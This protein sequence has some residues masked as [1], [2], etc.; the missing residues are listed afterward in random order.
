VA[1]VE[2]KARKN[3]EEELWD[4]SNWAEVSKITIIVVGLFS[5]AQVGL[6]WLA[7]KQRT[8]SRGRGGELGLDKTRFGKLI[9]W[10]YWFKGLPGP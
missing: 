8:Q 4:E 3:L 7:A 2:R 5:L 6:F 10:G 9:D 1:P